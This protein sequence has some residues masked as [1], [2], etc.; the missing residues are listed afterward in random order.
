MLGA[1]AA[2]KLSASKGRL[3]SIFAAM[4]VLVAGYMLYR[5]WMAFQV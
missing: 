2:R 3:N 4:I 5:T 1:A